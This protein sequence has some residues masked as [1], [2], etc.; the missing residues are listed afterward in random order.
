MYATV[1]A[2]AEYVGEGGGLPLVQKTGVVTNFSSATG[3]AMGT[4]AVTAA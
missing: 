3:V 2:G 4:W 1:E